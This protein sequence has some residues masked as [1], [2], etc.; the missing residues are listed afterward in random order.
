[1]NLELLNLIREES[2]SSNIVLI[3]FSLLAGV[4][5]TLLLVIIQQ[6]AENYEARDP[7]LQYA[8]LFLICMLIFFICKRHVSRFI[9]S[10]VQDSLF[11]LRIKITDHLRHA[12]LLSYESIGRPKILGSLSEKTEL[13]NDAAT[14]LGELIPAIIIVTTTFIYLAILSTTAFWI[15][16]LSIVGIVFVFLLKNAS[17]KGAMWEALK[18]E[19]EFLASFH[20]LL[21]GFKEVKMNRKRSD[22]LYFNYV[23]PIAQSYR[24]LRKES[25]TA[26]VDMRIYVFILMFLMMASI[27]FVLPHFSE[28]SSQEIVD[29][30]AVIL[31]I[32]GPIGVCA[33]TVPEVAKANLAI[34]NIRELE[35]LLAEADDREEY[36]ENSSLVKKQKGFEKIEFKNLNFQYPR[37][38]SQMPFS[39]GPVNFTIRSGKI[40]F[41]I[42]GNGSGKSTLLKLITGLY[43][44]S[45]GTTRVDKT[46][47][48]TA[49]YAHYREMFSIIFTDF[50]LFDRFYGIEDIVQEEIDQELEKLGLE[51]K[52]EFVDGR[53]SNINLSTG[54]KKRLAL[55]SAIFEKK[56]IMIFDEVAAD[57]DPQFRKY[58]YEELLQELKN[59]GKTVIAVTHDDHY[60]HQADEVYKMDYGKLSVYE[61]PFL[62]G[63]NPEDGS[64]VEGT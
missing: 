58:F 22:D 15:A 18:T 27:A 53:F 61:G 10:A 33:T 25:E 28:L 17:V 43:R 2:S 31:F 49:N 19:E 16:L 40:I 52:T 6:A 9:V 23:I 48:T 5:N 39:V 36:Q 13:I 12:D 14:Q 63:E 55:I 56:Q 64:L 47:V 60:F 59:S 30:V 45:I 54:Q 34:R 21:D 32:W 57:Q 26:M 1:M 7:N 51:E 42:G 11:K 8:A 37:Q 3:M 46:L 38:N 20:H 62:K 41:V 50:H 4:S 29:I 24:E 44:A 35:R